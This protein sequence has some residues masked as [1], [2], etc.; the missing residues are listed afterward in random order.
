MSLIFFINFGQQLEGYPMAIH[1]RARRKMLNYS[2]IIS[3]FFGSL[4]WRLV[5]GCALNHFSRTRSRDRAR[6]AEITHFGLGFYDFPSS[7][8]AE[9][10]EVKKANKKHF[11]EM[12]SGWIGPVTLVW[13]VKVTLGESP[14]NWF[15]GWAEIEFSDILWYLRFVQNGRETRKPFF[16]RQFPRKRPFK[17]D[18][19][20]VS[21]WRPWRRWPLE[22]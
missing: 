9:W 15:S 14:E 7:T 18:R 3:T 20:P 12:W 19:R 11:Q 22:M 8:C 13:K 10:P 5:V 17:L 21:T 16:A 4:L 1:P 2:W 6:L